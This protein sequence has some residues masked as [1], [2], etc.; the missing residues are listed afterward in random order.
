MHF[1]NAANHNA[2]NQ[3][4]R[5]KVKYFDTHQSTSMDFNAY[6]LPSF[7]QNKSS[8]QLD[9][10]QKRVSSNM[11]WLNSGKIQNLSFAVKV[12]FSFSRKTVTPDDSEDQLC[13][14]GTLLL[15]LC[16]YPSVEKFT[17]Q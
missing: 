1:N 7:H 15:S 10:A 16:D 9:K 17:P 8:W 5:Y 2:L 3:V 4:K 6:L 11:H 12:Q 14:R 13:E